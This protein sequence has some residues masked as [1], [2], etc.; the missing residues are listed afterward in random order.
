M[1]AYPRLALGQGA[2]P[3]AQRRPKYPLQNGMKPM[4][5]AENGTSIPRPLAGQWW[6]QALVPNTIE[7]QDVLCSVAEVGCPLCLAHRALL[8]LSQGWKQ[9]PYFPHLA[10]LAL[11]SP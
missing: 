3:R 6:H 9:H 1:A 2:F 7:N 11:L 10:N 5:L 4:S 8:L